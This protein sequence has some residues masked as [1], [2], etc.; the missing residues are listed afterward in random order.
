ML[1]K[2]RDVTRFALLS[3]LMSVK[4]KQETYFNSTPK[5]SCI[6]GLKQERHHVVSSEV[7]HIEEYADVHNW[8]LTSI[9]SHRKHEEDLLYGSV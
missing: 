5:I 2:E 7:K 8:L 1:F 3:C 9:Q 6:H 4:L